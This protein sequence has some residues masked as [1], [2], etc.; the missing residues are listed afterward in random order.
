[1][2]SPGAHQS[3]RGILPSVWRCW[4]LVFLRPESPFLASSFPCWQSFK[5]P[6][7]FKFLSIVKPLHHFSVVGISFYSGLTKLV[8][9]WCVC[10]DFLVLH[11]FF[12]RE[13]LCVTAFFTGR[14]KE[15]VKRM[16]VFRR[17]FLF[18]F[19]THP[20]PFL[21]P[22]FFDRRFYLLP[23]PFLLPLPFPLP[24]R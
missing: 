1:M 20:L 21:C 8:A 7:L 13:L 4:Q 14:K 5:K 10:V 11:L 16:T 18:S 15:V 22:F 6:T 23:S 19:C 17:S 12:H 9:L 2:F 24:G 3:T